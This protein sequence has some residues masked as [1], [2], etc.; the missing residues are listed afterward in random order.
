VTQCVTEQ[1][2]LAQD[3]KTSQ[4]TTRDAKQGCTQHH[5][6]D[7]EVGEEGEEFIHG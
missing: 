4:N 2:L 5:I 7:G 6:T 1:T 3:R